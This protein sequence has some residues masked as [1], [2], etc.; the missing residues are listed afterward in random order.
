MNKTAQNTKALYALGLQ[1]PRWAYFRGDVRP[2]EE[3]TL[4]VSC[5]AVNRGLNVYEGLKGYWQTGEAKFGI[6]EL[7]RHY[8][9]LVR[10]ARLLHIPVPVTYDE[11][12]NACGKLVRALYEPDKDMWVRATL[13]VVEGHW[14]EGTVAD[15][16]LTAYHQ[17]KQP[18]TPVSVGVSTWQRSS[19][20]SLSPRIKTSTNY[21]VARLARIEG[22]GRGFPEMILLNQYGRVAEATG[23]CVLLVRDGCVITPPASEGRLESITLEIVRRICHSLAIPFIERPVDRTELH[24]ADEIRLVGTLAELAPVT[25]VDEYELPSTSPLTDL[26]AETFWAAVRGVTPHPAVELT[27]V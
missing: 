25:C 13:Y 27:F 9:R 16:V 5:E 21:Q 26:I 4:H 10:S 8:E 12:Q 6:V 14:G 11:F 7:R 3:A 17:A 23:A 24:I 15:L 22:R 19:D 18:P 1:Q 20:I 2:W